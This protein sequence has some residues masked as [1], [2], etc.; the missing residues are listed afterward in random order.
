MDFLLDDVMFIDM[1][2]KS[3]EDSLDIYKRE[4]VC[5]R[6]G[7]LKQ[8]KVT[9]LERQRKRKSSMCNCT[10]RLMGEMKES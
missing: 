9:E 1:A 3:E 6:A 4:F 10:A 7:V 5:D 2:K 8:Q